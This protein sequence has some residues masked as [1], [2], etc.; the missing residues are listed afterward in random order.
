MGVGPHRA[1]VTIALPAGVVP[2]DFLQM[3]H[4]LG[5]GLGLGLGYLPFS[6]AGF[7]YIQLASPS[8]VPGVPWDSHRELIVTC[9]SRVPSICP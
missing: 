4:R 8:G 7:C 6:T 5:L 9:R 2:D 3:L 1:A